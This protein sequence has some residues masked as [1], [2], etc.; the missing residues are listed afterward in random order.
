MSEA[1]FLINPRRKKR[2]K[3]RKG[4]MPAGLARYWAS[5]R[6]GVKKRRR[7]RRSSAR[8]RRRKINP[9]RSHR[10][11]RRHSGVARVRR[12]KINPRRRRSHHARRRHRNPSLGMGSIKGFV[13]QNILPAA[14]GA[15]GA[16]ALD[17]VYAYASPYL[18]ATM[19]T[20]W[21]ATLA[22]VLGAAGVGFAASKMLGRERGRAVTLGALT[23]V[24]YG[25]VKQ[26]AQQF[27]PTIKGL[28][29]YADYVG[30][31]VPNQGIGAYMGNQLGFYSPASVIQGSG[32]GA[33]MKPGMSG[34]GDATGYDWRNDG[35]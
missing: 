10:R 27:A 23:V 31:N 29:G 28:S 12:R 9:V 25:V 15:T 18:P 35:M 19:Q 21:F 26:L 24:G 30:Y 22:K 5:R 3:S 4:R 17:V 32:M 11:R 2:R 20:G 8:V 16:V 33:Y 34:L 1:L 6:G 14:I 7:K 13:R